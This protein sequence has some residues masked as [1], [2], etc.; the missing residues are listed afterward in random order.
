MAAAV[1]LDTIPAWVFLGQRFASGAINDP[2]YS[3]N[4]DALPSPGE[5]L[6]LG[7]YAETMGGEWKSSTVPALGGPGSSFGLR[8]RGRYQTG[9]ML[10]VLKVDSLAFP[11]RSPPERDDVTALLFARVIEIGRDRGAMR[12]KACANH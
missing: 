7:G 2:P 10:R 5:I 12:S 9:A 1:M 4:P 3:I 8:D 11:P 6:C